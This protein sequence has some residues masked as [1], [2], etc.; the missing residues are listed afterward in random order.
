MAKYNDPVQNKYPVYINKLIPAARV[1][2]PLPKPYL[3]SHYSQ[4]L[5]DSFHPG[6]I[7]L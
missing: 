6:Y 4:Q 2:R 5:P 1:V 7:L 3:S